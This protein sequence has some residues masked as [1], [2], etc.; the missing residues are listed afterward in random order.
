MDCFSQVHIN[1]GNGHLQSDAETEA[2][3]SLGW[4]AACV[5]APTTV[6][7]RLIDTG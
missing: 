7:R 1:K 3:T 2:K 4:R 6:H 5:R